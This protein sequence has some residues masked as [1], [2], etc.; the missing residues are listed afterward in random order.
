VPCRRDATDAP[1]PAASLDR[2][3][4][5]A[6]R[7]A[8][9]TQIAAWRYPGPF[10]TYDVDDPSCLA[11]DHFAVVEAGALLGYCC[12]GAPAR[13]DGAE[14]RPGTVDVG[15][16]MAPD[17]MGRGFGHRFV[18]AVLDFA[19]E[20]YDP[21]RFRLFVLEWNTRSSTV[22]ER[23]GF[24]VASALDNR[25]GRFLVMVRDARG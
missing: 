15:Y 13:V 8:E 20:R 22:A 3:E 12:F 14:A 21:A 6:L 19:L 10:S 11:T 25:E 16:G 1:W 2:V 24:A 7:P 17:R 18:A 9:S 23:H 4:V 5:R